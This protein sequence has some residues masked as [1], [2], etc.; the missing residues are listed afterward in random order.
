MNSSSKDYLENILILTERNGRVRSVDLARQ[1]GYSKPSISRAVHLLEDDGYLEI[2]Q[3]G[4]IL[5]TELGYKT[6]N[7]IYERHLFLSKL[8]ITLGVNPDT[9]SEDAGR[10]GHAISEETYQAMLRHVPQLVKEL[11]FEV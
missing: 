5:L 4:N 11:G 1:M 10:T 3:N 2:A 7:A 8:F 9:A 6:A